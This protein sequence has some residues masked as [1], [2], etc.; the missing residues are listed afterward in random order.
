[1]KG[2]RATISG[3]INPPAPGDRVKLTFFANGSPLRKIATKSATL[4]AES[5]FKKRF[6]VPSDST[7]CKV[8]VRFKGSKLGQKKFRC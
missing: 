1:V 8:V 2:G 7:R 6:R 5:R 3:K 4:N